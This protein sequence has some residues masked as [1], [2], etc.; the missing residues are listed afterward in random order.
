M[1]GERMPGWA[2][3]GKLGSLKLT[4]SPTLDVTGLRCWWDSESHWRVD[5]SAEWGGE[6]SWKWPQFRQWWKQGLDKPHREIGV[7]RW[8]L[9]GPP[10]QEVRERGDTPRL[11]VARNH[12]NGGGVKMAEE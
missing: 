11:G 1:T 9:P 6:G 4:R 2:G 3:E 10:H 8:N 5:I 7:L 12:E